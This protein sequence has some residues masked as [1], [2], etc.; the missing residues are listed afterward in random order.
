M[1]L[2][3]TFPIPVNERQRVD[4]VEALDIA[5]E[6]DEPFFQY[7]ADAVR[8]IYDLPS[9]LVSIVTAD[10]QVFPAHPGLGLD[11]TSRTLSL[12][13]LT[14]ADNAPLLL[15]DTLADPRAATHPVVTGSLKVR[16]YFGMPITLS[17]GFTIGSLCALGP[18]PSSPPAEAQLAQHRRLRD[19]LV[20]FIERPLEPSRS[21]AEAVAAA[22]ETAQEEFLLLVSHELRTPLNGI[23]GLAQLLEIED[24]SQ[25]EV[26][27]GIV[28]SADLLAGI[29]DSI[30]NFTELRGAVRLV[31]GQADLAV[32]LRDAE[33]RIASVAAARGKRC[34]LSRLPETLPVRCDATRLGLAVSCLLTNFVIHGGESATVG[35]EP[36]EDGAVEI[37]IADDG[38]GIDASRRDR[39][40]EVFG[41]GRPVRTRFEDGLGLGLPLASRI[42]E[43]HGGALWL[44]EGPRRGFS[45][46][47][48][49]PAWRFETAEPVSVSV[50]AS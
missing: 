6:H 43:L 38:A 29:V 10:E 7:I 19:M 32:I 46:R 27:D 14:V 15:H 8:A 41:T 30:L 28:Q 45:V 34:D 12:C 33:R 23:Y 26:A 42:F 17:S 3:E 20:R 44:P 1:E 37:T 2:R 22:A 16:T 40:L 21:K 13:A 9:G 11:R 47:I 18:E 48:S 50:G 49:M 25:Q 36:G 5:Q 31:E 35:V 4:A 39:V 24:P